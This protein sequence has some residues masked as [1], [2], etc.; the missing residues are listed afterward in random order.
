MGVQPG[1][2]SLQQAQVMKTVV[3]A[4]D[5]SLEKTSGHIDAALRVPFAESLADYAADTASTIGLGDR[6]Y[7]RNGSPSKPG[8]EG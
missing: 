3:M 2:H 5:E 4:V 7:V 8:L 1:Q 6:D